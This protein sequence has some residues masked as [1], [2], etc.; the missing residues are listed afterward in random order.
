MRAI[1]AESTIDAL[2]KIFVVWGYPLTIQSDNGPPFQSDL[3][4]KTWQNRGI[5]IQKS[6]PMSPQSNGAIERQNQG[7]KKALAASKLDNCNWR[8]ALERYVHNHNKVRPLSRLGVTPF[9]LLVGWKY[10]GTFPCLWEAN[11]DNNLD[12]EEIREKDAFSKQESKR[13]TDSRRGAKESNLTVGDTVV[14]VQQ[15]RLK[16]DPTFGTEKYTILARD[17]AKL[18]VRSDRGVV[19]SRNVEDAKRA[20]RDTPDET[21]PGPTDKPMLDLPDPDEPLTGH[22]SNDT[23]KERRSRL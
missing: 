1:N 8:I 17:G 7:I 13:Y 2:N 20:T 14:L 16:S 22:T 11:S 23:F 12:R 4:V 18:V 15:K 9:E 6:I 10:R 5:A 21:T 19:Y 3:F